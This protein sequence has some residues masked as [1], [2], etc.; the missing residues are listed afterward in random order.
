[1]THDHVRACFYYAVVITRVLCT[2]PLAIGWLHQRSSRGIAYVIV[3]TSSPVS[4]ICRLPTVNTFITNHIL[5]F[6]V[7]TILLNRCIYHL[8]TLSKTRFLSNPPSISNG[9]QV[10]CIFPYLGYDLDLSGSFY[11]ITMN[12]V[13]LLFGISNTLFTYLF[14]YL[15]TVPTSRKI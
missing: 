15:L 1:M 13:L 14:I 4:S 3:M 2:L 6:S 9:F 11:V 8:T 5:Y 10:I 12:L 7:N